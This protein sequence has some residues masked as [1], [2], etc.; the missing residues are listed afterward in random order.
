MRLTIPSLH[1]STW[2]LIG[3]LLLSLAPRS[4][5]AVEDVVVRLAA[6]PDTVWIGEKV[7]L[8]LDTLGKDGWAQLKKAH[9]HELDGGY[10]KRFETQGTRLQETIEGAGYTGQR[11]EYFFFPQRAG[12]LVVEPITIDVEVKRWGGGSDND[13]V[14]TA[15]PPLELTVRT[16]PG[17]PAAGGVLISTAD[18][19]A[20]QTWDPDQTEF[21]TGDAVTRIITL[22]AEDVS[23]M[24]F[25][26]VEQQTEP[27]LAIYP[28]SPT[29]EDTYNRGDLTGRRMEKLTYV[30]EQGGQPAADDLTFTWWNTASAELE[31]VTLDGRTFTVKA[32][33]GTET[34]VHVSE[35][36]ITTGSFTGLL[37]VAGAALLLA[38]LVLIFKQPVLRW[39]R[40]RQERYR[41]SEKNY[42]KKVGQAARSNDRISLL[43]SALQ[44][45]D[46]IS[47]AET[48][49]RLDEFLSRYG[50]SG[51]VQAYRAFCA[52]VGSESDAD[53]QAF[54]AAL[55]AARSA[56]L[57]TRRT[58]RKLD[59]LLPAIDIG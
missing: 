54:Y 53:I 52:G 7:V 11:Y 47:P 29:V 14:R 13:I 4:L 34:S 43:N 44:W 38:G 6:E 39:Y 57:G 46:R 26:P 20:T 40:S 45:L 55:T 3:L 42:F 35:S 28:T 49:P 18:F 16:P 25:P 58:G 32:A 59:R 51:S 2:S 12:S 22:E 10:L 30:M 27:G 9:E 8:H 24:V 21:S 56:W 17:V 41:K 1:T 19:T 15:T 5:G 31:T 33:P 36:P 48:P 50:N 23:G 37:W